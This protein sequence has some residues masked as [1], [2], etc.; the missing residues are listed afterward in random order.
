M[1][2][3]GNVW[4]TITPIS[5]SSNSVRNIFNT[6]YVSNYSTKTNNSHVIRPT[7]YLKPSVKIISGDGKSA[8]TAYAL[9]I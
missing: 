1:H 2:Y 4:W 6:G 3:S 7:L 8:S 9:S 5:N